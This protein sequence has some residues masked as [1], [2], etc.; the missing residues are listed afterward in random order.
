ML[1]PLC[2]SKSGE[3][4]LN[5]GVVGGSKIR[6]CRRLKRRGLRE[7]VRREAVRRGGEISRTS[8][9]RRRVLVN[10]DLVDGNSNQRIRCSNCELNE[11]RSIMTERNV[12]VCRIQRIDLADLGRN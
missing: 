1:G 6:V 9:T 4:A 7:C 12:E 8:I 11:A 5:Q 2:F 10:N 3:V